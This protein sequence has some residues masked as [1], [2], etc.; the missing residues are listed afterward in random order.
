[1]FAKKCSEVNWISF[2]F[3]SWECFSDGTCKECLTQKGLL[4]AVRYVYT[5]IYLCIYTQS[6]PPL[7]SVKSVHTIL[8]IWQEVYGKHFQKI[9]RENWSSTTKILIA[10]FFWSRSFLTCSIFLFFFLFLS[11]RVCHI[12]LD[13]QTHICL[14]VTN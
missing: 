12:N 5:Y 2:F 8:W 11:N 1:M 14:D 10:T 3:F 6:L 9:I 13:S 7:R 4:R